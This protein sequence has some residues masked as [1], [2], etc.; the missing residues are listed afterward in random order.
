MAKLFIGLKRD[1]K[2]EVVYIYV[3]KATRKVEMT[4]AIRNGYE[5]E[6]IIPVTLKWDQEDYMIVIENLV[7]DEMFRFHEFLGSASVN[8]FSVRFDDNE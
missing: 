4:N 7:R 5:N 6:N 8:D 3:G 1:T 2:K